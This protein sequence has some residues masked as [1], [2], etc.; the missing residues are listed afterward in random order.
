MGVNDLLFEVRIVSLLYFTGCWVVFFWMTFDRSLP[1]LR[2]SGCVLFSFGCLFE[3][4]SLL[5]R[6]QGCVVYKSYCSV[7]RPD[8]LMFRVITY[9][10]QGYTRETV[11]VCFT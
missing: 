10:V 11:F 9:L 8:G 7:G 5:P 1:F 4:A 3:R 6:D 2:T